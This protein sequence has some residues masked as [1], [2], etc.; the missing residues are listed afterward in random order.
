MFY[1][2]NPQNSFLLND[3][4]PDNYTVTF[5]SESAYGKY[6]FCFVF[7]CFFS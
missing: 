3:V 2:Q 1:L 4:L 7:V 5:L 6:V